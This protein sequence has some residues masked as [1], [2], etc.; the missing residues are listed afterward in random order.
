MGREM[1]QTIYPVILCG[2]SGTRLWPVSRQRFPKQFAPFAQGDSLFQACVKRLSGEAFEAPLV[3]TQEEFRFLTGDQLDQI[4]CQD[5]TLFVEPEARNTAPAILAAALYLLAQDSE[6]VMLVA[7]SDHIIPEDASFRD[8]VQIGKQAATDGKIVLFGIHP[9]R[10][11]TGYGYLELSGPKLIGT[12]DPVPLT[13]FVEKPD[14]ETAQKM[15]TSGRFLW[16]AGV[17]LLSAATLVEAFRTHAPG[18]LEPVTMAVQTATPDLGFVR[19]DTH[20][21]ARVPNQSIDYAVMEKA[22]NLMVVPFTGHWSDMG[23][24][25]SV[26]REGE[27]DETGVVRSGSVQAFDCSDSL[28]HSADAAMAV[29]GLGL[30]D[31]L[32]VATS[33]SVLVADKSKAQDVKQVVKVLR[34]LNALQADSFP[35]DFRPWGWFERLAVSDGFQVKRIHVN[36]GAALSLQTHK[37][38]SEH[39]VVVQGRAQVTLEDRD[40]MVGENQSI[41]IPQ[42]AKHRLRNTQDTP[43]VLIEVQ[44]GSYLGEDDIIR[45]QDDY[46]R[47]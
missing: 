46:T 34:D 21:W 33:D 2:G 45:Y 40:M 15:V 39:W 6:A 18:F 41:Y 23:D 7:P 10:A 25:Q 19:L 30:K 32:V 28:I 5:R 14:A 1:D 9:T 36:P 8:T 26:W 44:T 16:N 24:W 17:F 42:G 27:Q 29:V 13:A 37:H 35:K 11:E 4:G 22:Q 12:G 43:L 3:L 38:R 31:M 47:S 20:S